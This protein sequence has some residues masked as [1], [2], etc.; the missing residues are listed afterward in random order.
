MGSRAC[1][2]EREATHGG[3]GIGVVTG[4]DFVVQSWGLQMLFCW[5]RAWCVRLGFVS[6]RLLVTRG[7]G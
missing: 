6:S 5:L 7:P 4:G 2:E 3:G 1:V